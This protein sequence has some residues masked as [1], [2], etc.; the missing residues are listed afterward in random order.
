VALTSHRGKLGPD[1]LAPAA[2]AFRA[3]AVG[4]GGDY[5]Q[6]APAFGVGVRLAGFHVE[7]AVI[8]HFDD[9]RLFGGQQ[10]EGDRPLVRHA[11]LVF[12]LVRGDALPREESRALIL[13]AAE[14][15]KTR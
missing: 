5:G 7:R 10:A 1:N 3:P 2:G 13:E 6:A 15:W 12:D 14:Q 11:T 9:E 4:E 8:P